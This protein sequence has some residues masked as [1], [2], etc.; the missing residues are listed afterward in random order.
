[1]Y[2]FSSFFVDVIEIL[3][4]QSYLL[5]IVHG[6]KYNIYTKNTIMSKSYVY[7]YSIYIWYMEV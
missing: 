4:N 2:I 1:M 3:Y 7:I 5:Y 6:M